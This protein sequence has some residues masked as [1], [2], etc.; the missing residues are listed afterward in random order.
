MSRSSPLALAALFALAGCGVEP[1]PGPPASAGAAGATGSPGDPGCLSDPDNPGAGCT[2][3]TC[4][5][6]PPEVRE[7][8]HCDE[9]VGDGAG[10]GAGDAASDGGG[11]GPCTP[12]AALPGSLGVALGFNVF[13]LGDLAQQG[14]DTEGRVAVG[15]DA[16]L[17]NYSIGTA[18]APSNGARDDLVTG[19]VLRFRDGAVPNG[20]AVYGELG[21][22]ANVAFPGGGHR[23]G[24]PVDFALA[25]VELEAVSAAWAALP[26][27][28]TVSVERNGGERGWVRLTGQGEGL[29]V[30][31]VAGADLAAAHTLEIAVPDGATALVNVS[32]AES[33]LT[34]VGFVLAGAER[35]RI[36]FNFFAAT[37]LLL[38][39]VGVEGSVIAPRADVQFG[40]GA[41][42]GTLVA[43]S[44][45]GTGESHDHAFAGCL[46]APR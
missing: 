31:A 6:A 40:G 9:G 15:G 11:L 18:L 41:L 12:S 33:A 2:F 13:V 46:P 14:T 42:N 24:R 10:A 36:V 27:T 3:F 34:S 45:R 25:R 1:P 39:G 29:V 37:R 19:G 8:L 30:F 7:K 38:E 35:R 20:N 16:D 23:Q 44:L 32:G 21:T 5:D 28:G 43:G 17:A 4:D 22:L 26:A